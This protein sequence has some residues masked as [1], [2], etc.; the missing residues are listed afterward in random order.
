MKEA[1]LAVWDIVIAFAWNN[2]MYNQSLFQICYKTW[3]RVYPE[4]KQ[5]YQLHDC[6]IRWRPATSQL[7]TKLATLIAFVVAPDTWQ[8][9]KTNDDPIPPPSLYLILRM[10]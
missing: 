4:V 5:E 10:S 6:N 3:S 8:D 7:D 1:D 2:I 9:F